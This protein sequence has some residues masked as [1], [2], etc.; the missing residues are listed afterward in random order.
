M[1]LTPACGCLGLVGNFTIA[2]TSCYHPVEHNGAPNAEH[3]PD[4]P[5]AACLWEMRH[6]FL[7]PLANP[8]EQIKC[9]TPQLPREAAEVS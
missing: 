6:H 4:L 3:A 8:T 7:L 2:L 1:I 5:A 9:Q